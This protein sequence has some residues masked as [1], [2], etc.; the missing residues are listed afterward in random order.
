MSIVCRGG[1][2][3]LRK[4]RSAIGHCSAMNFVAQVEDHLR[5]LGAEA[6][7]AHPGKCVLISPPCNLFSMVWFLYVHCATLSTHS[8]DAFGNAALHNI[9]CRCK[10][11]I[12]ASH[13]QPPLSPNAIRRSGPSVKRQCTKTPHY[14]TIPIPGCLTTILTSSQLFRCG[15]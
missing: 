1:R 3:L 13:Y 11:S 5:D 2:W 6:R 14:R 8:D 9:F 12:R 10:R 7:K 4:Q 15:L